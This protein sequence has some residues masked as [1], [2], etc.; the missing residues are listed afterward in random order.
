MVVDASAIL[1]IVRDEPEAEA[2]VGRILGDAGAK[3]SVANWLEASIVIDQRGT[4][5][6][7]ARFDGII[8]RLGIALTPVSILQAEGART[9]YRRF[10]KGNHP[11]ALNFGDCFAYALAKETGEPLL[12]TGN[13]FSRTDIQSALTT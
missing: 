2:F 3:M 13:D 1:A 4:P 8:E 11:A 6:S 5:R 7:R 9:A 10:G 12:F